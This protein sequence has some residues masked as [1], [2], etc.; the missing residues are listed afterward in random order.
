MGLKVRYNVW[1]IS[2]LFCT[3]P[4]CEMTK[5]KVLWTHHGEFSFFM[6]E[7]ERRLYEYSSQIPQPHY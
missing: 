1:Y 5:F 6:L 2:F 4:Q 3:K 7:L